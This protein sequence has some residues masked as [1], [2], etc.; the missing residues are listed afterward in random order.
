[1]TGDPELLEALH[2]TLW[3]RHNLDLDG[4]RLLATAGSNMAFNAIAQVICDLGDQVILPPP[5]YFNH[6]MAVQL[7][8]GQPMAVDAGTVPDPDRLAAAITPRTRAIVTT[9]PGHPSGAVLPEDRLKAINRLC[10]TH[11][12][13]HNP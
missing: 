9:S 5:C 7:A 12:L 6:G 2:H 3:V 10:E 8:G 13:F 1:M 11:G 4:S